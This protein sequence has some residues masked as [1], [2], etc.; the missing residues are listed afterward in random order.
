MCSAAFLR[1]ATC[2]I[3][4]QS[5]HRNDIVSDICDEIYGI[6]LAMESFMYLCQQCAVAFEDPQRARKHLAQH[7]IKGPAF[8]CEK[9]SSICLTESNLREHH[10]KHD[11]GKLSYR[12]LKCTPNKMFYSEST[13]YYHLSLE[14]SV[15]MIAFCKNCLVAS[16]NMDRIFAH[17]ITRECSGGS[18]GNLKAS[19]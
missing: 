15:P 19:M 7:M 16:A 1:E 18:K 6:P 9:C 11:D 4:E 5:S 13:M 10:K 8:P 2:R 17:V 14:H 3:H 12:C